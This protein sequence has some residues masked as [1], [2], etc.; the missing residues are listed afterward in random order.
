[1]RKDHPILELYPAR[2][3]VIDPAQLIAPADPPDH[4]V[5]CFFQEAIAKLCQDSAHPFYEPAVDGRG[6]GLFHPGIGSPAAAGMVEGAIA[7]GCNGR[8]SVLRQ[9]K[10]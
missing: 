10:P 3:S 4:C 1:M 5:I 9:Q 2:E 8:F 7:R 6:P